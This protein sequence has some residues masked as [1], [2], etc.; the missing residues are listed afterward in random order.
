MKI[1]DFFQ[2]YEPF[3]PHF[4]HSLL[5]TLLSQCGFEETSGEWAEIMGRRKILKKR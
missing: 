4:Q 5:L 3:L 1:K 2:C